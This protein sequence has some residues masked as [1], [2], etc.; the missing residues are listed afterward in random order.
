MS[1]KNLLSTDRSIRGD[2]VIHHAVTAEGKTKPASSAF[3]VCDCIITY[4]ITLNNKRVCHLDD[5]DSGT[6]GILV[7][8]DPYLVI[9]DSI[10]S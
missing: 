6:Y 10:S 5:L 9:A 7:C 3:S 1:D 8:F 2:H 4:D